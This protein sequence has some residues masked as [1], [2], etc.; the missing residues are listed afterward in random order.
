MAVAAKGPRSAR[1]ATA[2]KH[3]KAAGGPRPLKRA[4]QDNESPPERAAQDESPP[5]RAA[6]DESPPKRAAQ[7]ESPPE[8]AAQD[9]SPPERAA[10]D[11]SPR[12]RAARSDDP[13]PV[14]PVPPTDTEKYTYVRRHAWVLTVCALL[15]IPPLVYGQVRMS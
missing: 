7:G 13:Y 8:R 14:L 1:P 2:P 6:Q 12:R 10:Q 11:E 5:K 3:R 15:S 4:V 9:E